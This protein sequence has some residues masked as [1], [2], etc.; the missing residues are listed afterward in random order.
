MKCIFCGN[1]TSDSKSV[2]HIIPQSFGN[3]TLILNR[4]IVCDKCNNYFSVEIERPF[5]EKESSKRIRK[6]LE[7]K[8]KK[9]KVPQIE[10]FPKEIYKVRQIS[11][12]EYLYIDIDKDATEEKI[13]NIVA[14]Y[15]KYN[16]DID[17]EILK[18]DRITCRLLAKMAVEYFAYSVKEEEDGCEYIRTEP[19]FQDIIKFARY[20][21]H[22]DWDFNVRRYYALN[23]F[24]NGRLFEEINWE[25]NFLFTEEGEVYFVAILFGIEYVINLGGPSVDGY[26]D[27]LKR[28][29][30]ISPLYMSEE[31]RKECSKT[32]TL[33]VYGKTPEE[34]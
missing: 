11:P 3:S 14:E 23:H 22:M 9:G 26:I 32:Y 13:G 34:L 31:E 21:P 17:Q 20:N 28:H 6:E 7:I 19:G 18:K 30:G 1:D 10:E 12:T 15:A 4:G 24:Y 25:C 2:E 27:W 29:R 16:K 8:S 33:K 5:L